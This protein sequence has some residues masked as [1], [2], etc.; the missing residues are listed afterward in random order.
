[1]IPIAA[2]MNFSCKKIVGSI[3]A[4]KDFSGG[5]S[6]IEELA[7]SRFAQKKK[8]KAADLRQSAAFLSSN[9]RRNY[10]R[11]SLRTEPSSAMDNL[12]FFPFSS[13]STL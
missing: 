5:I 1:M 11:L 9:D 4:P 10:F 12:V 6:A 13:Q 2:R 8:R 3:T 7:R